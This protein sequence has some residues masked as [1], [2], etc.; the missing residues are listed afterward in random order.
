MEYKTD[1]LFLLPKNKRKGAFDVK[2]KYTTEYAWEVLMKENSPTAKQ[3]D[4]GADGILPECRNCRFHRPNWKY[5]TCVYEFCPYSKK[6]I[7]TRRENLKEV[8]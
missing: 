5:D 3:Y 1:P 2:S 4:S 7:S 6:S 8:E